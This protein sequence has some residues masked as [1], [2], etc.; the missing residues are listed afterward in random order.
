M[1]R[2][3]FFVGFSGY[4]EGDD[5][6]VE[7]GF[8]AGSGLTDAVEERDGDFAVGSGETEVGE[9]VEGGTGPAVHRALLEVA[10]GGAVVGG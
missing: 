7:E 8:E 2:S 9:V 6:A 1:Q 3:V 5:G 4:S 10:I